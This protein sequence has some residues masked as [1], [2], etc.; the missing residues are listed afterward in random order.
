MYYINKPLFSGIRLGLNSET[1]STRRHISEH[2]SLKITCARRLAAARLST[3]MWW[4]V[5]PITVAIAVLQSLTSLI[6]FCDFASN[7]KLVW[8]TPSLVEPII[9]SIT[10]GIYTLRFYITVSGNWTTVSNNIFDD[11]S[12]NPAEL[13]NLKNI[14]SGRVTSHS[15]VIYVNTEIPLTSVLRHYKVHCK[16]FRNF[17]TVCLY[18]Y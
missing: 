6:S 2:C 16:L 10:L 13:C 4:Y 7:Q 5:S 9:T 11:F 8:M 14:S 1:L 15:D 18:R 17:L 12:K 3:L